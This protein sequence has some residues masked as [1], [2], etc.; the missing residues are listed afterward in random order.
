[1]KFQFKFLTSKFVK[2]PARVSAA[3]GP[4]RHQWRRD[5]WEICQLEATS[6]ASQ[7]VW[8]TLSQRI[9]TQK[10]TASSSVLNCPAE[11]DLSLHHNSLEEAEIL[12]WDGF[13]SAESLRSVDSLVGLKFGWLCHKFIFGGIWQVVFN[14]VLALSWIFL[15]VF[16][17][18]KSSSF[19]EVTVSFILFGRLVMNWGR[20]NI[21]LTIWWMNRYILNSE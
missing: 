11:S 10:K 20:Q 19:L 16:K 5:C 7:E 1:M 4:P 15:T 2:L 3:S 14:C 9:Q 12:Q 18:E 8:E 17:P 6:A 21:S 13:S